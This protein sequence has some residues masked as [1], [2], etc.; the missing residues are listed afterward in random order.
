MHARVALAQPAA[1][2]ARAFLARADGMFANLTS[3]ISLAFLERYPSPVDARVLGEQRL[4]AFLA[5]PA[6]QGRQEARRSCSPSSDARPRAAP[7]KPRRTRAARSC[8]RSSPRCSSS[9]PRSR[10]S[11]PRSPKQSARIPTARSSSRS[12]AARLRDL[13]RHAARGDRRLPR[14]LPNR[15]RARRRRRPSRRSRSSPANARSARSAGRCDHRLRYAFGTLADT[16]R[17]WHPWAADRY[18]C[19]TPAAT[20]THARSAPSAAPGAASSG[21]AG[22]T[23]PLTTRPATAACNATSP[24]RSRPRRAPGPT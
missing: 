14:P 23:A 2:G 11:T 5:A 3:P 22:K 19:A 4:A 1:R 7:A 20:T 17:H 10:S 8:S 18:A 13:R 12:S 15:R 6:L 16:T 24:S 21:A 9:S